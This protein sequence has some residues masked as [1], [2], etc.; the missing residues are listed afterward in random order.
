MTKFNR[1]KLVVVAFSYFSFADNSKELRSPDFLNFLNFTHVFSNT[2]LLRDNFV[3]EKPTV[4]SKIAKP[5]H[6]KNIATGEMSQAIT[7]L[8]IFTPFF[9]LMPDCSK[10]QHSLAT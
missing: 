1:A 3:P 4:E 9:N 2:N 10:F 5:Q 6:E 7:S 8:T